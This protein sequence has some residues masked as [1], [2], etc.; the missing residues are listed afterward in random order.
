MNEY[1]RP[2]GDLESGFILS[3]N[4]KIGKLTI[5]STGIENTNKKNTCMNSW[6]TIDGRNNSSTRRS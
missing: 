6:R 4:V 2:M 3:G 1:Q 5:R